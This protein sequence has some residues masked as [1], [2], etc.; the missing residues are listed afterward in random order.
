MFVRLSREIITIEEKTHTD[1]V[2]FSFKVLILLHGT[3]VCGN[4]ISLVVKVAGRPRSSGSI[5]FKSERVFYGTVWA[6]SI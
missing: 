6:D 1:I 4:G 5:P 3:K 2:P